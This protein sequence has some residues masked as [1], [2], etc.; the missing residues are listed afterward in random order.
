MSVKKVSRKVSERYRQ[1]RK[2]IINEYSKGA[3]K[4]L[5]EVLLRYWK[6]Q[7]QTIK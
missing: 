7:M 2:K 3:K 5:D 1:V 6:F 4:E